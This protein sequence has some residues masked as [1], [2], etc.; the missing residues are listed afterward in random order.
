LVGY[1]QRFIEGFSRR[2]ELEYAYE[3]RRYSKFSW[4]G[5]LLSKRFIEGFLKITK[6]ITVLLEKDNKFKWTPACEASFQELEK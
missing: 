6:P 5:W 3:C 1:Y 2:I 4:I